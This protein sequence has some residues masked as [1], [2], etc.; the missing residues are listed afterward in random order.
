VDGAAHPSSAKGKVVAAMDRLDRLVAELDDAVAR[1][2][3]R[4]P[5]S[6]GAGPSPS[7]RARWYWTAAAAPPAPPVPADARAF[8]DASGPP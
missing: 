3:G 5:A 4:A 2:D 6:V 8:A 7:P 1:L